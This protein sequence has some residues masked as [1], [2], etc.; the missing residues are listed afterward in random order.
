MFSISDEMNCGN[1]ILFFFYHL[2]VMCIAI[3]QE[4][5]Y[6]SLLDRFIAFLKT[7]DEDKFKF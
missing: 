3:F 6:L 7:D 1:K 2:G 4:L 5:C